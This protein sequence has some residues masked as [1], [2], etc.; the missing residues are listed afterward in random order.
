[1]KIPNYDSAS[2][3]EGSINY[4]QN[5]TTLYALQYF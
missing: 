3:K 2:G 1:M 4:T 5:N